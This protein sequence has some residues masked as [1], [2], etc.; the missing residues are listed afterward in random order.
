[1]SIDNHINCS[2]HTK[3]LTKKQKSESNFIRKYTPFLD[4]AKQR[5]GINFKL[6]RGAAAERLRVCYAMLLQFFT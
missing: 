1:V 6:K 5:D 2:S 4:E 3:N